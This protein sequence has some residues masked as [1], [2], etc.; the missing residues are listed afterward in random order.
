MWVPTVYGSSPVSFILLFVQC[1]PRVNFSDLENLTSE[2]IDSIKRKGSVVVR[3]VVDIDE[4]VKW[5]IDM[6]EFINN[7]PHADGM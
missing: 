4:A 2:Q 7:N 6:Q 1:I 5:K 3:G